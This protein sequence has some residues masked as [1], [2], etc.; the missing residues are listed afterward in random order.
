MCMFPMLC[1]GRSSHL[2]RGDHEQNA[3][4]SF[5]HQL[6]G[7]HQRW[8]LTLQDSYLSTLFPEVGY[9]LKRTGAVLNHVHE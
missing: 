7:P 9:L 6:N 5:R 4:E 2:Q 3:E 8:I 1:A